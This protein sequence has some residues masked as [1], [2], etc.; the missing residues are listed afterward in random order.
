MY[1][2]MNDEDVAVAHE[3]LGTCTPIRDLKTKLL[4]HSAC[5]STDGKCEACN[6]SCKQG[7]LNEEDAFAAEILAIE[8]LLD[9]KG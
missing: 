2:D 8:N 4:L 5:E 7:M 9:S 6:F 3:A 1:T